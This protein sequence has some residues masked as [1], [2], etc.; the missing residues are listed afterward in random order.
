MA[1]LALALKFCRHRDGGQGLMRIC[2]A[3]KAL[4]DRFSRPVRWRR[5]AVGTFRHDGLIIA[6]QGIIGMKNLVTIRTG[7]C[8]MPGTIVSQPI[9]MGCMAAGT[10][11][12]GKRLDV[13][14]IYIPLHLI[15]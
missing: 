4:H 1:Y 3:G 12:K 9:I 2:V 7:H 13:K 6:A 15:C 8:L 10:I 5:V 14:C 11:L